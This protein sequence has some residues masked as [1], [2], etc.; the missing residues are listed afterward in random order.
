ML[1]GRGSQSG[2]GK[3]RLQIRTSGLEPQLCHVTAR[4]IVSA[5][6][7][8]LLKERATLPSTAWSFLG[9]IMKE[10]PWAE[11]PRVRVPALT[12]NHLLCNLDKPSC[13]WASAQLQTRWL[14]SCCSSETVGVSLSSQPSNLKNSH[15]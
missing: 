7:S 15:T 10:E 4:L 9:I 8:P 1:T 13:P 14:R 12:A 11:G 2:Q 3:T 6:V 5:S